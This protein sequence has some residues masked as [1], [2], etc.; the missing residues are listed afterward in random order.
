V[1]ASA[2]G[3]VLRLQGD[4]SSVPSGVPSIRVRPARE[5]D[6][7]HVSGRPYRGHV[8]VMVTD[9]G[10]VNAI[11][12]LP[13]EDYLLGVVPLEIGPR[14]PEE[15]AAVEA[16]AVAA[17][18]YAVSQLGGQGEMGFDLFGTVDDQAYGGMAVER[19]EST[20]AVR[21]TAG[22]IL[23]FDG[24]PIRAYYHSTCGG[25]TAA[26][27]EVMDREPAPYLRS[28]SDAG[29]DGVDFC[30]ASPRYEW[31]ASWNEAELD[32]IS[33]RGL[34]SVFGVPA[35]DLGHIE[36]LQVLNRTPSGRVRDLS[37]RGP[38]VDL[39]VSRLEIRRALPYAGG[40]LNSTD[41]EVVPRDD[42]LVELRGRG[43][44]H[45]AGMCQWGA[46]G[47]A[48]AGQSYEQILETYYPGAVLVTAYEGG[49]G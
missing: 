31:T 44:G 19:A 13:L 21:Q 20:R 34:A 11:N 25:R 47:R 1:A 22:R 24:R 8:E 5:G 16:Q 30:A 29:L 41:F 27:E 18:T 48:R 36:S 26:V 6:P 43:Y 23:L 28:V 17:R 35:A 9:G 46:I 37:F 7:V 2:D 40:I 10:R 14:S 4:L 33:R 45:G 42:G 49:D 32:S 12:V 15:L 39:V 3:E 38:G